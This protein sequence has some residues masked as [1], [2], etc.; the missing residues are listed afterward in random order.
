MS[1]TFTN[2]KQHEICWL[3]GPKVRTAEMFTSPMVCIKGCAWPPMVTCW[4]LTYGIASYRNV[5]QWSYTTCNH[6]QHSYIHFDKGALKKGN[7]KN[8]KLIKHLAENQTR[9]WE[10][11]HVFHQISPVSALLTSARQGFF[12]VRPGGA[13]MARAGVDP[14]KRINNSTLPLWQTNI[15]VAPENGWLEC[16]CPFG[17]DGLFSGAFG[18]VSFRE[19]CKLFPQKKMGLKVVPYQNN[20]WNGATLLFFTW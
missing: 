7:N 15:Q 2:N 12:V 6:I 4:F 16:Q 5:H 19:Y 18:T 14:E 3:G 20:L 10:V 11:D 9:L 1:P 17:I 13:W 8:I